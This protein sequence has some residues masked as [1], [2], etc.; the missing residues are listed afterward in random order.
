MRHLIQR[1]AFLLILSILFIGCS[2]L[3]YRYRF[4]GEA[5][6]P[7]RTLF[8]SGCYEESGKLFF[9]LRDENSAYTKLA[10]FDTRKEIF[11]RILFELEPGTGRIQDAVLDKDRMLFSVLKRAEEKA[12]QEIYTVELSKPE[13]DPYLLKTLVR[14]YEEIYPLHLSLDGDRGGWIEQDVEQGFSRIRLYDFSTGAEKEMMKVPFRSEGFPIGIYF[15]TMDSNQIIHDQIVDEKYEIL[16][17]NAQTGDMLSRFPVPSEIE[18]NY[19]GVVN[20][21]ERF[22]AL[23]AKGSQCDLTYIIDLVSGRVQKLAGFF[24]R[25]IVYDDLLQTSGRLVAYPVQKGQ[26]G[27]VTD[28][29]YVESY[30]IDRFEMDRVDHCFDLVLDDEYAAYLKFDTDQ[31]EAGVRFELFRQ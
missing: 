4:S 18:V 14:E 7:G 10:E 15:L 19:T 28:Q 31:N 20:R 2:R 8:N 12:L 5:L 21:A 30:H 17:R 9:L 23:Y 1:A 16:V 26:G 11:S 3:E 25:S 22:L 13:A 24:P 29:F 6:L 27:P